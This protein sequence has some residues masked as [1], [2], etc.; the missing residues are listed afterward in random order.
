M[1]YF[2]LQQYLNE[3]SEST[4]LEADTVDEKILYNIT[5][6]GRETLGYFT[7]YIP[8][9]IKSRI[10]NIFSS[11]REEIRNENQVTADFTPESESKFIV[12]C[13]AAEENF[14]LIELDIMVGTKNDARNICEN[15]KKYSSEIYPEIIEILTKK[16]D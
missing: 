7:S 1:N 8:V 5:A 16:R 4:F 15:W 11:L 9:G 10:D 3:L 14:T 2:I 12:T 13:K 6:S